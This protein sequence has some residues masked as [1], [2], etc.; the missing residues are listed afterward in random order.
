MRLIHPFCFRI[1]VD[2]IKFPETQAQE[3]NR[4]FDGDIL[5]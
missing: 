5:E 4:L 3:I 2:G 1:G